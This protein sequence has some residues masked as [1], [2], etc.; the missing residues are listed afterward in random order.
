MGPTKIGYKCKSSS[1]MF[2]IVVVASAVQGCHS[3][4]PPAPISAATQQQVLGKLDNAN[5]PP[6]EKQAME[7]SVKNAPIKN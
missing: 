7:S 5:L 6:A 2:V 4:P 3:V 1:L